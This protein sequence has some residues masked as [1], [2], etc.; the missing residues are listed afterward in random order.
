MEKRKIV[1]V[2]GIRD[3]TNA[4]FFA[5]RQVDWLGLDLLDGMHTEVAKEIVKWLAS[6]NIVGE[7]VQKPEEEIVEMAKVIG[8]KGVEIPF[9]L[10]A[11]IL[12][13]NGLVVF[14]RFEVSDEAIPFAIP[15][16]RF[17]DYYVLH[18]HSGGESSADIGNFVDELSV[19]KPVLI[20]LKDF[21]ET[22]SWIDN[23][24]IAGVNL[25]VS[26]EIRPG[27]QDFTQWLPVLEKLIK[28][29]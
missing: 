16:D 11:S 6:V 9:E 25:P 26:P 27:V 19:Q 1:K 5:S 22:G 18:I 15:D 3:L 20:D 7:F 8:L 24:S 13:D 29:D 28:N 4:R 14:K 17:T 23:Y 12:K 21:R 10:N 2:S